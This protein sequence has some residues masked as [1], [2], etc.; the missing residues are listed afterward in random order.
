MMKTMMAIAVAAALATMGMI[1][2]VA[3]AE[4]VS[5]NGPATGACATHQASI[6]FARNAIALNSYSKQ[7]IA[8]LAADAKACGRAQVIADAPDGAL[9]P[10]RAAAISSAFAANG[11]QAILLH[12]SST[13]APAADESVLDRAAAVRLQIAPPTS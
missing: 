11:V 8:R 5:A 6:Y 12:A 1:E 9:K 10:Q 13:S 3:R 4:P 7:I 2:G